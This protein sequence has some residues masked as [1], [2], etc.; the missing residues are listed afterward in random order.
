MVRVNDR[1]PFHAERVIDLSYVAAYKLGYI[2]AGSAEVTLEAIVPG[3]VRADAALPLAWQS[4]LY[5]VYSCVFCARASVLCAAA[6]AAAPQPPPII[7]RSWMVGDL[8]SGQ[9]LAAHKADERI[10]PASLT[11]LMT[12]YLVFAALR[13]KKLALEQQV[14]RVGARLARAGLAHVHRA[15][16]AGDGRRADPRHGWCSRATTPASRSPRRSP[17]RRKCSRR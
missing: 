4:R 11:K 2:Q 15:A 1:G 7:G 14:Q 12:A 8:S 6:H 3:Q 10:E 16:P 5:P 13:E 17:A 9:V